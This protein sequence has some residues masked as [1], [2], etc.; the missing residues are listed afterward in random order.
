MIHLY[1]QAGERLKRLSQDS[2]QRSLATCVNITSESGEDYAM[3][4]GENCYI[5]KDIIKGSTP[6]YTVMI[7]DETPREF[8]GNRDGAIQYFLDNIQELEDDEYDD[9]DE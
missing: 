8:S 3:V 5:C 6:L 7:R 1:N 9:D 4:H 2:I